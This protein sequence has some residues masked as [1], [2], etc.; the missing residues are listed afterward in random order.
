MKLLD[1]I[2]LILPMFGE[3]TITRIDRKHP[4]VALI[5]DNLNAVKMTVLAEGWWFNTS[6]TK[7]YP[8]P[9][10]IISTPADLLS[11]ES[12]KPIEARGAVLVDFEKDSRIFKEPVECSISYDMAFEDLPYSVANYITHRTALVAYTK[13]YGY[14]DLYQVLAV[15]EQ[16]AYQKMLAEHLRKKKYSSTRSPYAS[17]YFSALRG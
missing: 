11:I 5:L 1:A 9:E 4:T 15:G 6:N 17:K 16:K 10:G 14:E 7:L 12:R 2:N 8:N 3:A 13:D